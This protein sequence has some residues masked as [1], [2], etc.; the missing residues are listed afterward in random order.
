MK[1]NIQT[2]E[3]RLATTEVKY[4]LDYLPKKMKTSIP[5]DFLKFL[6]KQ[7]IPDYN[8]NFDFSQGLDKLKLSRKTKA[9]LAMIYRNFI[10]SEEEKIK[11]DKILNQN[12]NLYQIELRKKY[13][14]DEI[15]QKNK[16]ET[17]IISNSK[18]KVQLVEYKESKFTKF[19][20]LLKKIF[21]RK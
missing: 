14:P 10:C 5:V 4:I 17:N 8:P 13:N 21:N 2:R 18:D 1:N 6:D 12:E 19:I 9:L 15:F 20:N 7:S 11:Y 16:K 3:Y